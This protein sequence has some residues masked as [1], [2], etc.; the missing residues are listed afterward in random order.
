MPAG[1]EQVAPS[2]ARL[3]L[4]A[5]V[6]TLLRVL[7][8]QSHANEVP[9]ILAIR[10]ATNGEAQ[11]LLGAP[12]DVLSSHTVGMSYAEAILSKA[13]RVIDDAVKLGHVD[14][15]T[16][17]AMSA[18]CH[19]NVTDMWRNIALLVSTLRL[20]VPRTA[21]GCVSSDGHEVP[22]AVARFVFG[23]TRHVLLQTLHERSHGEEECGILSIL[24]AVNGVE[25]SGFERQGVG[26]DTSVMAHF[27][28]IMASAWGAFDNA[29][30]DGRVDLQTCCT[31]SEPCQGDVAA[32]LGKI[33]LLVAT[34]RRVVPRM[35]AAALPLLPPPP[36]S[37][38]PAHARATP[39]A[40]PLA[41]PPASPTAD[42]MPWNGCTS[43]NVMAKADGSP[44]CSPSLA[45]RRAFSHPPAGMQNAG[46]RRCL[47]PAEPPAV[48]A[49]SS[50]PQLSSVTLPLPTS[51]PPPS[52][53]PSPPSPAVPS[54]PSPLSSPSLLPVPLLSPPPSLIQQPAAMV[55]PPPAPVYFASSPS[56]LN[57]H[58]PSVSDGLVDGRR[59]SR[60]W[61]CEWENDRVRRP[62]GEGGT[63]DDPP[64]PEPFSCSGGAA[65]A[66][67]LVGDGSFVPVD[68]VDDYPCRSSVDHEQPLPLAAPPLQMPDAALPSPPDAA[69][70]T[71]VR[72]TVTVRALRILLGGETT[73]NYYVYVSST[74]PHPYTTRSLPPFHVKR[75]RALHGLKCVLSPACGVYRAVATP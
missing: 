8:E 54:P 2:V 65:L 61:L 25:R 57:P 3:G 60:V 63:P 45:P 35:A 48:P 13:W 49:P 4:G 58:T 38:S 24:A 30:A 23:G 11:S 15:E 42:G 55:Q 32:M 34:L 62:I 56:D 37:P 71:H 44:R 16:C 50:M 40:A 41:S 53:P 52:A 67:R 20:L 64:S 33:A 22:P 1:H 27:D 46:V 12:H 47:N 72:L 70:A 43:P 7:N 31:L 36:A 39:G 75:C 66:S 74:M 29:V 51:P 17:R 19:G 69:T 18:P 28:S 26:F 73:S 59:P 10:A 68:G 21:P 14:S 5:P 9:K 6:A